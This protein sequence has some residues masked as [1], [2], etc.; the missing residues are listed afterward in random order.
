V[1]WE[2]VAN[3]D[4]TQKVKWMLWTLRT[5]SKFGSKIVAQ[6]QKKY[7]QICVLGGLTVGLPMPKP[8]KP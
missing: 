2:F 4:Q 3:H 8:F 1:V 5:P 6:K 7:S